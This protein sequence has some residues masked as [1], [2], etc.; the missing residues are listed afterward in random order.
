MEPHSASHEEPF[1]SVGEGGGGIK[2]VY[3]PARLLKLL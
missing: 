1:S 3:I 2:I